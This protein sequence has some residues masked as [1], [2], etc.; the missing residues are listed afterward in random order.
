MRNFQDDQLDEEGCRAQLLTLQLRQLLCSFD[1][2]L[3]AWNA[4]EKGEKV[5]FPREKLFLRPV[6]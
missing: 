1:A 2:L 6:R 3:E 5:D 4:A